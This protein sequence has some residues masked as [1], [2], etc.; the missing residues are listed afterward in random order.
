MEERSKEAA[1]R[2]GDNTR[3]LI[4]VNNIRLANVFFV[5]IIHYIWFTHLLYRGIFRDMDIRVSLT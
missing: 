3:C 2:E 5:S 1:G 4:L